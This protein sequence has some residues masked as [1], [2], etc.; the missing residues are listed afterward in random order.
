MARTSVMPRRPRPAANRLKAA[1]SHPY[2][3]TVAGVSSRSTFRWS[4]N[5]WTATSSVGAGGG[6]IP[7]MVRHSAGGASFLDARDPSAADLKLGRRAVEETIHEGSALGRA[8]SFGQLHGLVERDVGGNGGRKLELEEGQAD[9]VA[10]DQG[11]ALDAPVARQILHDSIQLIAPSGHA[12]HQILD[13]RAIEG[14]AAPPQARQ[15]FPILDVE[16][17]VGIRGQVIE[18][19]PQRS[20]HVELGIDVHLNQDL[21]GDLTRAP[22]RSAA[23]N[24][25]LHG[26]KPRALLASRPR[27]PVRAWRGRRPRR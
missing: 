7:S 3:A 19:Q 9:D 10:L 20:R 26:S 18:I 25:R 6:D 1:R 13:E 8:E 14:C 17:E 4:R 5:C 2:A 11:H 24:Y 27:A 16:I 23:T 12:G 22:T 15:V 21:Q